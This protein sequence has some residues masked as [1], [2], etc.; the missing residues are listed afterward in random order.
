MFSELE[1]MSEEEF[2]EF[3]LLEVDETTEKRLKERGKSLYDDLFILEGTKKLLKME[4]EVKN[5]D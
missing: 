1:I 2:Q 5:K 3:I 4:E